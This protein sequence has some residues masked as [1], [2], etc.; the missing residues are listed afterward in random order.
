MTILQPIIYMFE[1]EDLTWVKN[2]ETNVNIINIFNYLEKN[3][4]AWLEICVKHQIDTL[5]IVE[6]DDNDNKEQEEPYPNLVGLIS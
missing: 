6:D 3:G 1:K 2:F 5:D 4:N